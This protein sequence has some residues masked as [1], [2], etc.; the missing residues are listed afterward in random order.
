M[1]RELLTI[2]PLTIHH[3]TATGIAPD[4]HRLPIF[5][6]TT[7]ETKYAAN[8]GEEFEVRNKK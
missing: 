3:F 7:S 4:L 2:L 5:I 8:V 1:V 6:P